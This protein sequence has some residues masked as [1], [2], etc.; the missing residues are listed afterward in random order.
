MC[1]NVTSIQMTQ[2]KNDCIFTVN[3]K[4]H[5][6]TDSVNDKERRCLRSERFWGVRDTLAACTAGTEQGDGDALSGRLPERRTVKFVKCQLSVKKK[7][8]LSV[9]EQFG[10]T[11]SRV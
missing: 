1:K 9:Q 7:R 8:S 5:H 3:I 10:F 6:L 4:T 11:R 2:L